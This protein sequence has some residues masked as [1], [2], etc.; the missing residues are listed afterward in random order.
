MDR[1]KGW[2]RKFEDPIELLDGRQLVTLHDAANYIT[3]LPK[4][5]YGASEWQTA[6]KALLLVAEHGGPTMLA[7][8]K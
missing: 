4:A 6:T 5:E 8:G 7:R 2:R 3:K 1:N